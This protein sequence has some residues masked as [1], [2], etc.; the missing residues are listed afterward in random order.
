M[1]HSLRWAAVIGL[2][3]VGAARTS[4]AQAGHTAPVPVFAETERAWR[5]GEF[6]I[7]P[8]GALWADAVFATERTHPGPFSLYVFSRGAQGE[9]AFTIDA[10]RTRLG[11]NFT[12]PEIPLLGDAAS[13]GRLEIDFHGDFITENR[14]SL[15]LRHAYWE[16][17]TDEYRILIGQT[18]DVMSPLLPNTLSYA[19]GFDAGNIGYRRTQFR[20]ERY[21]ALRDSARLILQGALSQ[22]IVTD[23]PT[24]PGV[25]REASGWP[26][27]QGRIAFEW[28]PERTEGKPFTFGV[29]GHIGESGFDFTAPGPPPLSLPPEDDARF[30][31]WSFNVDFRVPFSNRTGLRGEF[32]T[33][34]NLSAFL[35]GIGQGVCGCV[36]KPIHS[37]GGWLELWHDWNARWHSHVGFGI[38]DPRNRD[39]RAPSPPRPGTARSRPSSTSAA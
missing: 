28:Q 34:A 5:V 30:I 20:Y 15:L 24:E 8:Y 11:L 10:R 12:G 13:G 17:T 27:L 16:A 6:K 23:F 22:D 18:W 36:R 29:S 35:G 7:V 26:V 3:V 32:F 9:S 4:S 33:G 21:V 31:T 14:A 38:D 37:T 25:R 1:A 39:T 2:L 19:V